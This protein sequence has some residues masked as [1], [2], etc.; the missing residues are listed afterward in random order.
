M[1]NSILMSWLYILTVCIRVS[2]SF[3]F[4]FANSLMSSM[5]IKWLIFSWDLLSL[6]PTAHFLSM[7][8]SG[9]MAI[10]KV[11]VGVHLLGKYLFGLS[12]QRS[13]FLLLSIPFSRFSIILLNW[14]FFTTALA[15]GFP[16]ESVWQQVSSH[17]QDSS[18]Y[19][20]WCQ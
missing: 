5:Y 6:Y 10:W 18:Q 1:P 3:S 12:L 16:L 19:S 8:L 17:L 20:S 13:F 2:S 7:W 4:F 14:E 15:D 11:T 9:T